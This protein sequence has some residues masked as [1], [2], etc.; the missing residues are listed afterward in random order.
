MTWLVLV[1]ILKGHLLMTLMNRVFRPFSKE[2]Y[3]KRF[4]T[5][6]RRTLILEYDDIC[7]HR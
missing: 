7:Q 5:G 4:C 1:A 3:P 6:D 2:T